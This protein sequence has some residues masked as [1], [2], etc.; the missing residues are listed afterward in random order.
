MDYYN[1][2]KIKAT[3]IKKNTAQPSIKY[4]IMYVCDYGIYFLVSDGK[5]D[6]MRSEI[7][8]QLPKYN[9]F[10]GNPRNYFCIQLRLH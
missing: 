8:T 1:N 9:Y 4:I 7:C 2:Y 5:T 3:K 10:I 6:G